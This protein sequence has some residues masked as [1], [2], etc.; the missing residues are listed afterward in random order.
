MLRVHI[1]PTLGDRRVGGP[2][3]RRAGARELRAEHAAPAPSDASTVLVSVHSG[4][5]RLGDRPARGVKLPRSRRAF[6]EPRARLVAAIADATAL[7]NR[8]MVWLGA[9]L[10]ALVGG[11]DCA[12]G[13]WMSRRSV[14]VA[15]AVTRTP[16]PTGVHGSEVDGWGTD[17]LDA[18]GSRGDA[19]RTP[20][21]ARRPQLIP[22]SSCS[23]TRGRPL[24]RNWHRTDPQRTY[25][26][27]RRSSSRTRRRKSATR[28]RL[29]RP[30]ANATG[31]VLA[32][33][34]EDRRPVADTP[35]RVSHCRLRR[36]RATDKGAAEAL[37]AHF[38]TPAGCSRIEGL[39]PE[40]DP[41]A[42]ATCA[43]GSEVMGLEPTTYVANVA[44]YRA[45][46]H[47]QD[48]RATCALDH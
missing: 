21:Q 28:A 36:L 6:A 47:P 19:R 10:T 44:L 15:E 1:V 48:P 30:H 31:L 4:R 17:P 43:F 22:T 7:E 39:Q 26:R 20:D 24:V 41:G 12:S 18:R 33:R 34:S 42:V 13:A 11:R 5:V 25:R 2:A 45:E 14:A 23:H 35:I 3:R 46:L 8:P 9:M 38:S 16:R 32:S 27:R 29:P 37:G 40:R